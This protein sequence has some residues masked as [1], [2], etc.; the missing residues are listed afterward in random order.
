MCVCVF[1]G[2]F[3][4]HS[5][6]LY[7][8]NGKSLRVQSPS[9]HSH[10]EQMSTT[11]NNMNTIVAPK[12]AG[13][14]RKQKTEPIAEPPSEMPAT[15]PVEEVEQKR[16]LEDWEIA[17]EYIATHGGGTIG[18]VKKYKEMMSELA[19]LRDVEKRYKE[20][21]EKEK[22]LKAKRNESSKKSKA[23][24]NEVKKEKKA[25]LEERLEK[26]EE[27][28]KAVIKSENTITHEP[29]EEV[30]EEADNKCENCDHQGDDVITHTFG[31]IALCD[32]CGMKSGEPHCS[33]KHN[34]SDPC[35]W[36]VAKWEEIDEE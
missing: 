14:P 21:L 27:Q 9:I 19:L 36:C 1:F 31:C 13:R 17:D 32:K 30:E 26:V 6:S 33:K 35:D 7:M 34:E 8:G 22:L 3:V 2:F 24:A 25:K 15:A 23:K 10:T 11:E 28:L 12:K 29:K 5:E 20:M 16:E 18:F 4:L